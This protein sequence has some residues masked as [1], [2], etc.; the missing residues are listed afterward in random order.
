ME[1][2]TALIA[3]NLIDEFQIILINQWKVTLVD[4][5]FKYPELGKFIQD[6]RI[7]PDKY[8]ESNGFPTDFIYVSFRFPNEHNR[9]IFDD[10][11][12]IMPFDDMKIRKVSEPLLTSTHFENPLISKN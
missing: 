6:V 4:G 7:I 9:T 3:N 5:E 2:Y 8:A 11:D 10:F 12:D 1:D